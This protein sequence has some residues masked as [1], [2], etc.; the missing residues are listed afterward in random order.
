MNTIWEALILGIIQGLTE[1]LPVSSSGHLE[2]AK[3]I[4]GD[5]ST[6]EQ[7]L[8]MTVILH[9]ATAFATI[10]VFRHDIQ[11]LLSKGLKLN[12]N[13]DNLYVFYIL[14]SMIPAALVG[15][16]FESAV[17]GLLTR[18]LSWLELH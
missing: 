14:V 13:R 12:G 10:F 17:E 1:F 11:Q 18:T 16:F 9:L 8:V 4:L 6:P 7:S 5:Q 15:F 2:I 3:Y